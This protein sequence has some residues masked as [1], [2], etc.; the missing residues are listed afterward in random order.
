ML[1]FAFVLSI[2]CTSFLFAQAPIKITIFSY[3]STTIVKAGGDTTTVPKVKGL[4]NMLKWNIS[5]LGRGVFMLNYERSIGKNISI[6]IG[7]GI[8]YSDFIFTQY[9]DVGSFK[10]QAYASNINSSGNTVITSLMK[11]PFQ[12][13]TKFA[14]YAVELNP[15]Y[16]FNKAEFDGFYVSPFL[17]YSKYNYGVTVEEETGTSYSSFNSRSITDLYYT[18]TDLGFK[19]GYQLSPGDYYSSRYRSA[20]FGNSDN[21]YYD[22]YFGAAYRNVNLMTLKKTEVQG[23]TNTITYSEFL[24]TFNTFRIMGGVKFGFVF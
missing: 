13:A 6:E 18:F 12:G 11:T 14:G 20:W 4:Q 3:D 10:K 9:Y 15:R 2:C 5:L 24:E 19:I 17:S 23:Y 21:F 8:T 22:F 1:R 7:A 16:Y